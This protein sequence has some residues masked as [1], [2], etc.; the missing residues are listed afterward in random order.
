[1]RWETTR[2]VLVTGALFC[3]VASFFLYQTTS[4]LNFFSSSLS[5]IGKNDLFCFSLANDAYE[6]L[7]LMISSLICN[8]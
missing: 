5:F 3:F 8:F 1:M 7:I 6:E 4:S 2:E